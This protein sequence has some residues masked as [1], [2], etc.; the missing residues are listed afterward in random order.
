[1]NAGFSRWER[2]FTVMKTVIRQKI[3]LSDEHDLYWVIGK[4]VEEAKPAKA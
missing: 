3:R 2:A 4:T 1:M